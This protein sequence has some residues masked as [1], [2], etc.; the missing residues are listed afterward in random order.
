MVD[1]IRGWNQERILRFPFW[2]ANIVSLV[3][4]LDRMFNPLAPNKTSG[5][6]LLL[7]QHSRGRGSSSE[8]LGHF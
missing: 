7:S 1:F 6:I 3:G 4:Y 2:T 5:D 8:V